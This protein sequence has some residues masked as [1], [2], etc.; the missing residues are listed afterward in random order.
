MNQNDT[1]PSWDEYFFGIAIKA[2]ERANCS[3]RK[4]GAVI[5]KDFGII[6]TGYNG[7]SFGITNCFDGG[8]ERCASTVATKQ[9]YDTCIC[10]HAEDNAI[11]LAAKK[12]RNI[13]GASIYITTEPCINC[14]NRLIQVGIKKINCIDMSF[15][16]DY[17]NEI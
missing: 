1:R 2:A 13:E 12:G 8:C 4:I 10:I 14:L 17:P 9:N 15:V 11:L 3:R 6:T 7:T 5:V 16:T